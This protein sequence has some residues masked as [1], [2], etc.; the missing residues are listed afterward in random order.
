MGLLD[1]DFGHSYPSSLARQTPPQ[2]PGS[3][4]MASPN[5]SQMI[6]QQITPGQ[7]YASQLS[8]FGRHVVGPLQSVP[9]ADLSPSPGQMLPTMPKPAQLPQLPQIPSLPKLPRW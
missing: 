4:F 7:S 8:H 3:M 2:W 5:Y 1:T 9:R 6:P